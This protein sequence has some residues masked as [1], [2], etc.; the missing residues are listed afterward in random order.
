M[1]SS[2]A[3]GAGAEEGG[4]H[5]RVLEQAV[6]GR[7]EDGTVG[8]DLERTLGVGMTW[9]SEASVADLVAGGGEPVERSPWLREV[10]EADGGRPGQLGRV[11]DGVER[12][13]AEP[14]GGALDA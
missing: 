11:H 14:L 9:R 10:V 2:T 7:G 6:D 4:E 12:E 5:G 8:D 13:Q 1:A 3:A